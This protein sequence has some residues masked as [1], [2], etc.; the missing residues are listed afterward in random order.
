MWKTT[1]KTR[2]VPKDWLRG[3]T[4]PLYRGKGE[5]KEPANSIPLCILSHLR[6]IAE[7]AIVTDLNRNFQAD[8]AQYGFQQGFQVTQSGL[9]VLAAMNNGAEFVVSLDRAKAYDTIFKLLMRGK[10]DDAIHPNL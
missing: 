8:K 1:G 5:K 7:K 9:S 10:L 6:K 3:T 4:V 2:V